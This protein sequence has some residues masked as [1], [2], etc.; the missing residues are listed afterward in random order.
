MPAKTFFAMLK[1]GRELENEKKY[2]FFAELCD[3][4]AVPIYTHEYHQKLREYYLKLA[5][6]DIKISHGPVLDASSPE[7]GKLLE[8]LFAQKG[9][10]EGYG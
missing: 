3:I 8:S 1:A 2:S 6:P 4:S 9:R 7:T 10:L 5:F